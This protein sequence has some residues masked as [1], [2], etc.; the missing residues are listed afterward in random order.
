[1]C[2]FPGKIKSTKLCNEPVNTEVA[3]SIVLRSIRKKI[4]AEHR[5]GR[6]SQSS[7]HPWWWLLNPTFSLRTPL[8][9]EAS[10]SLWE[11]HWAQPG[12]DYHVVGVLG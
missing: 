2:V 6:Q 12:S 8:C 1:M 9:S 4:M 5:S 3:G 11:G 7:P 10:V